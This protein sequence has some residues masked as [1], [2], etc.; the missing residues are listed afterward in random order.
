MLNE[1]IIL[2]VF[3]LGVLI[4]GYLSRPKKEYISEENLEMGEEIELEE[5]FLTEDGFQKVA[6]GNL[7]VW[8][9]NGEIRVIELLE[10]DSDAGT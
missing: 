6:E 7:Q 5:D 3:G 4:W 9:K 2:V 10:D 1:V 8:H